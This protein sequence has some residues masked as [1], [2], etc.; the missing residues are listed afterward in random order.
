[1][2]PSDGSTVNSSTQCALGNK[3]ANLSRH[4]ARPLDSLLEQQ[5]VVLLGLFVVE[6]VIF[7]W[8]LNDQIVSSYP[9]HY[10]Q[11]SYLVQTYRL[12]EEFHARGWVAF[13]AEIFNPKSPQGISFVVQGALLSLLGG[14]NR[15]APLSLNLI[16]FIA[17]QFALFHTVRAR[18]RNAVL[19]W[20][21][22]A[23]LLSLVTVF[24]VA[25]GI[26]DYRLDFSALCLYGIWTCLVVRS[27]G[28]R[29]I[30]GALAISAV[31]VLLISLRFFTI[32]FL[33]TVFAGLFIAS[34]LGTLLN[35]SPA[36]RAIA[37]RRVRNVFVS[38]ALTAVGAFPLLFAAR[39]II[40]DYY[41]IG[42][43]IGSERYIRAAE[44]GVHTLLDHI[45]YYPRTILFDHIGQLG[46]WLIGALA[47]FSLA[48]ALLLERASRSKLV[49]RVRRCRFDFLAL[50][51]AI[52]APLTF[53]TL[54]VSKS[55]VVGGIVVVPIVLVVVLFCAAVWPA[56][57]LRLTGV[58]SR[59]NEF[60]VALARIG[61]GVERTPSSILPLV[62]V[63]GLY[64]ALAPGFLTRATADQRGMARPDLQRITWI[65]ESIINY[66]SDKGVEVPR[67][68]IDRVTDYLNAGTLQLYSYERLH[69]IIEFSGHFGHSLVATP[70]DVA[71]KVI[72]DSDIVVLTD[73]IRRREEPYPMNTKIRE[74]WDEMS[75]WVEQNYAL[76]LSTEILSIPHR[77]FVK[78]VTNKDGVRPAG[79]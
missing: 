2:Q 39:T 60:G 37:T 4:P 25:G 42:H 33:G 35:A 31:G 40:Y 79:G 72:A 16:Y 44:V 10:D 73:P 78:S 50:A 21:A 48:G 59:V 75:A 22:L 28:F 64:I 29:D 71:L 14:P 18:V 38:G 7:Y 27:R 1:M 53:L 45:L 67:M 54:D 68:S 15:T 46:L 74:Y 62:L 52:I 17:L 49:G 61:F 20:V 9:A 19:S 63:L 47:A 65:N 11:V 41:G 51:L 3:N 32:A 8:Q 77:V 34:V 57:S 70:R 5:N 56:T 55:P 30:K 26:Y 12:I 58:V 43:F 24:N 13:L 69:R 23:F 76:L 6:T 36:R 66:V